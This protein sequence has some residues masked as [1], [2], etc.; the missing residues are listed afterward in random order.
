LEPVSPDGYG[1]YE[2]PQVAIYHRWDGG[3]LDMNVVSAEVFF[4]GFELLTFV[5]KGPRGARGESMPI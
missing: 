4:A 1:I 5:L 2:A 3:D